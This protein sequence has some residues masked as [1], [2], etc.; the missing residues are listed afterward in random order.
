LKSCSQLKVHQSSFVAQHQSLYAFSI[1]IRLLVER[2][3]N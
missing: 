3:L 1:L 2:T